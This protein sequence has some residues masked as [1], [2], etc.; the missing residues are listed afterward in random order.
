MHS[1]RNWSPVRER[2]LDFV[3]TALTFLGIFVLVL[4]LIGF[5]G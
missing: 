1:T 2:V 4:Y 5:V 3:G